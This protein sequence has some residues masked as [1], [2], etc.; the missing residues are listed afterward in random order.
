[1]STGRFAS[2]IQI[3]GNLGLLAGL[4]LVGVQIQQNTT[5]VRAQMLSDQMAASI[6][7]R[8]TIA[9]ENPASAV[10]RAIDEPD[11]LTAEFL[12]TTY[13]LAWWESNKDTLWP[14]AAP[15][16]AARIE[17][18]LDAAGPDYQHTSAREIARVRER[19]GA[20]LNR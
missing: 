2:W 9:G 8:L 20:L 3:I 6:Q 5:A 15:V 18:I 11:K 17:K 12:G 4:I 1:M 19:I 7:L 13:G 10:A 14:A 16:T